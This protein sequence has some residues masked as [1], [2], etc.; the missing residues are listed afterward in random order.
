MCCRKIFFVLYVAVESNWRRWA[1]LLVFFSS[2][3]MLKIPKFRYDILSEVFTRVSTD[4][5]CVVTHHRFNFTQLLIIIWN[6]LFETCH[7]PS[8]YG[9][10]VT[11][12]N[13]PPSSCLLSPHYCGLGAGSIPLRA[14]VNIKQC[15]T[16]GLFLSLVIHYW[17]GDVQ[18][19]QGASTFPKRKL[20]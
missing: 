5:G 8:C 7:F 12:L 2:R 3:L 17:I 4:T 14:I 20:N 18:D 6:L 1:V 13:E 16:N 11:N 15:E 9:T 10:G 19:S